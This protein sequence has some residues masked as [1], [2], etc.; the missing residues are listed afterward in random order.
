MT[1]LQGFEKFSDSSLGKRVSD[2]A[3]V[4]EDSARA[5]IGSAGPLILGVREVPHYLSF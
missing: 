3:S 4:S 5:G 2:G 1:P